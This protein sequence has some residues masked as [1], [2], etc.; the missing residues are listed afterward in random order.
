MNWEEKKKNWEMHSFEEKN[1]IEEMHE[2]KK[3]WENEVRK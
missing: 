1:L 2:K 3:K